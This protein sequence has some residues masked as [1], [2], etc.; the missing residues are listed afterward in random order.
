MFL[1]NFQYNIHQT[2]EHNLFENEINDHLKSLSQSATKRVDV[3]NISSFTDTLS[4][5]DILQYV[6]NRSDTIENE[7]ETK[8]EHVELVHHRTIEEIMAESDISF[9]NI[10]DDPVESKHSTQSSINTSI[11]DRSLDLETDRKSSL[12]FSDDDISTKQFENELADMNAKSKD[13]EELIEKFL[14]E[15]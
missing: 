11:K 15:K 14:L 6:S 10:N 9:Q 5:G 7:Y 2:D 1:S 8:I 13:I 3:S 12:S 4:D